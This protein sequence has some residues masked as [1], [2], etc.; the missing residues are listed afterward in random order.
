MPT[1]DGKIFYYSSIGKP[2]VA[3]VAFDILNKEDAHWIEPHRR[4]RAAARRTADKVGHT[5]NAVCDKIVQ[6]GNPKAIPRT[7]RVGHGQAPVG[8][9]LEAGQ[10]GF[11]IRRGDHKVF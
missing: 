4:Q 5:I 2:R 7:D 1:V 10:A 11:G 9:N 3:A 8:R 6:S